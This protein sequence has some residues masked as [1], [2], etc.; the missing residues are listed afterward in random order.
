[1]YENVRN[2]KA[3]GFEPADLVTVSGSIETKNSVH[4]QLKEYL[5]EGA[6]CISYSFEDGIPEKIY[7]RV[8]LLTGESFEKRL[9][10]ANAIWEKSHLVIAKRAVNVECI[11]KLVSL[12]VSKKVLVV[13]DSL[14]SA[15]DAIESIQGIGFTQLD[16]LP[17]SPEV[18]L[19]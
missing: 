3:A 12:G 9:R 8:L 16:Y 7:A 6:S 1:M 17:Y 5:P 18:P 10:S 2:D 13:N 14:A 19:S 4:S 15:M 11:H